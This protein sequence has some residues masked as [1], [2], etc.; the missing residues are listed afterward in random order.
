[1][2]SLK[3]GDDG[4]LVVVDNKLVRI[5]GTEAI[6]QHMRNRFSIFSEEWF[7]DL[8]VG[9][10]YFKDILIKGASFTVVREILKT[11]AL[12]TRGVI[13]LLEF[14]FEFDAPSRVASLN[15]KALGTDDTI[16]FS[17]NIQ[18]EV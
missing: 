1:M 16:D 7:L 14:D 3:L 11:T 6:A 9:V 10:P 15:I 8:S 4:D 12:K 18:V 2:S 13:E 17:Q 5:Y